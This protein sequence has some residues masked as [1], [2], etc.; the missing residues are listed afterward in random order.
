MMTAG[1]RRTW[2]M[3]RVT[4]LE[5]MSSA[6]CAG[7]LTLTPTRIAPAAQM[8]RRSRQYCNYTF[9][10]SSFSIR[11]ITPPPPTRM[12]RLI[13][14]IPG[15][16]VTCGSSRTPCGLLLPNVP[17]LIT[18]R[19]QVSSFL[20]SVAALMNTSHEGASSFDN[21]NY[22]TMFHGHIITELRVK[23]KKECKE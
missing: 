8:L 17:S 9:S 18:S 5:A 13:Q 3:W 11:R 23:L 1:Q 12:F 7:A 14:P 15:K 4:R 10:R 6:T 21:S 22:Y 19:L 2:R 20:D 16:V